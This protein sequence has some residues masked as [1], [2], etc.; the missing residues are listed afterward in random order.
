[1]MSGHGRNLIFFNKKI[2]IGRPEHSILFFLWRL[3]GW[4]GVKIT[5]P[6]LV[7]S[8]TKQVRNMIFCMGLPCLKY[9]LKM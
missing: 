2:Q 6:P 4:G 3:N 9:C 5:P 1:M 7:I 8:R